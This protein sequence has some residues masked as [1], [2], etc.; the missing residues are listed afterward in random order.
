[1]RD[2][3][4]LHRLW[5]DADVRRYLWDDQVI[6]RERAAAVID[7]SEAD[8]DAHGFGIWAILA[9]DGAI[10]GFCGLRQFGQP[11]AVEIVY[12]LAPRLWHHGLAT[13]A[14]VDVLR[15]GFETCGLERIHGRTDPPN[16]ASIR[17][18]ER[19][20]MTFLA[21]VRESE[22]GPEIV[23]YALDREAFRRRFG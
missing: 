9:E 6:P 19:L 11:P 20:G 4:P 1:M 8:F 15:F 7:E 23:D 16:T 10:G 13:E 2:L 12:G 18:L 5:T 21:R 17:V 3:D 22:D 14:A